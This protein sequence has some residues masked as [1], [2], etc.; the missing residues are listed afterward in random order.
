MQVCW[1]PRWLGLSIALLGARAVAAEPKPS[2]SGPQDGQP[3]REVTL[4]GPTTAPLAAAISLDF[5]GACL[6]HEPL[7]AG[8]ERWLEVN[9]IH[10]RVTVAVTGAEQPELAARFWLLVDDQRVSLRRFEAFAGTCSELGAALSAAIALAIEAVDLADFPEPEPPPR[11]VLPVARLTARG[12]LE[13]DEPPVSAPRRRR[14]GALQSVSIAAQLV[15][16]AGVAPAASVGAGLRGELGF[17]HGM[18]ARVAAN[19]LVLETQPISDGTLAMRLPAGQAGVCWGRETDA[20]RAQGCLDVWGGALIGTP[21]N[22][23][24]QS[25]QVLPWMALAPGVELVFRRGESWGVRLGTQLCFNLVRPRFEVLF[26]TRDE[27]LDELATPPL[28]MM[29][30]LGLDW[31]AL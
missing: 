29:L 19:Y 7:V 27:T 17:A 2:V 24:R 6:E 13:V 31:N 9:R 8:V 14:P 26:N 20:Y 18:A 16:G 25:E 15:G 5:E 28:G 4:R 30:V 22:L 23:E 3:T 12:D 11:P 1:V 10:K 21:S